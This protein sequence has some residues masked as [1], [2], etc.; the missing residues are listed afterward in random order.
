MD[1][2][3]LNLRYRDELISSYINSIFKVIDVKIY[4]AAAATYVFD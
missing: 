3:G 2:R 4:A 1:M